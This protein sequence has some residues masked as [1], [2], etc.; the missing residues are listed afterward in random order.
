MAQKKTTKKEVTPKKELRKSVYSKLAGTL[1]EYSKEW[2]EKKL[3][4]KL[5]K[6]SKLFVSDISKPSKSKSKA[7]KKTAIVES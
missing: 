6:V 4:G 3:K 5:K 1:A 7:E 2:N